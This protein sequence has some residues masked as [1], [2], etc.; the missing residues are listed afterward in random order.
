MPTSPPRPPASVD[1]NR[2]YEQMQSIP[3]PGNYMHQQA[4]YETYHGVDA[5]LQW[6]NTELQPPK[7]KRTEMSMTDEIANYLAAILGVSPNDSFGSRGGYYTCAALSKHIVEE[8][9]AKPPR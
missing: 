2:L 3:I 9:L 1:F 5:P 6:V 7:P 4:V 8:I